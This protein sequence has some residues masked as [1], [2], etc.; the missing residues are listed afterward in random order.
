MAAHLGLRLAGVMLL[1]LAWAVSVALSKLVDGQSG[2]PLTVVEFLLAALLFVSASLGTA[3]ALIGPGLW[4]P[5]IL[6][7]RHVIGI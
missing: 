6:S 7:D 4:A 5:V 3:L 1:I 2:H